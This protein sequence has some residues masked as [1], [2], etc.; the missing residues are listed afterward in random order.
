MDKEKLLQLISMIENF[1]DENEDIAIMFISKNE[2]GISFIHNLESVDEFDEIASEVTF[3]MAKD[4]V[5][6]A[7][8]FDVFSLN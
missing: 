5:T 3:N 7:Q 8:F 4:D 1:I 2:D 6:L